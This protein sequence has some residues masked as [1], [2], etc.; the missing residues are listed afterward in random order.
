MYKVRDFRCES[1]GVVTEKFLTD[2]VDTISCKCGD[3]AVR[4]LSSPRFVLE[5]TSG[6]FPGSHMKWI[7]EH[8]KA[9]SK[10]TEG[11]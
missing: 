4:V 10:R 1:C 6:D 3:T 5:G 11:S 8:E 9:A 2:D 7:K